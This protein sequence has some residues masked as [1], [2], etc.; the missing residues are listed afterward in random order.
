VGREFHRGRARGLLA[1][2]LER[3]KLVVTDTGTFVAEG[4]GKI[5]ADYANKRGYAMIVILNEV[6]D[7]SRFAPASILL[8]PSRGS[9]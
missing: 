4:H 9:G 7:P 5:S 1:G 3:I 2:A 6:K 8:D